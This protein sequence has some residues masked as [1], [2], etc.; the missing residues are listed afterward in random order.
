MSEMKIIDIDKWEHKGSFNFFQNFDCPLVNV[1]IEFDAKNTYEYAKDREESFFLLCVYA[2]SK[3]INNIPEF[4]QR[5]LKDK[6]VA[7]FSRIATLTPIIY[8]NK[9]CSLVRLEYFEKFADYKK[10]AEPIIEDA[11]NGGFCEAAYD[12]N[13]EDIICASLL[14]WFSFTSM[15]HAKMKFKEKTYPVISW[16]KMTA[17]G[18]INLSMQFDHSF[19][20]GY[21]IGLFADAL[22]EA[23]NNPDSL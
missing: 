20:D 10:A 4:R 17:E 19:I 23:F 7:E 1:G 12:E 3:T 2:I 8:D 18:K 22:Q 5:L 21:H 13:A 11:K 16:G 9:E 15:V 6:R 14:P